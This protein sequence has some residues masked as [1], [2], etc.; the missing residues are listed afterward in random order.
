[1]VTTK[2]SNTLFCKPLSGKEEIIFESSDVGLGIFSLRSLDLSKDLDMIHD[3]VNRKYTQAFWQLKGTKK[4]VNS[5][6]QSILTNPNTHSLIGLIN[7]EPICQIDIYKVLADELQQHIEADDND[8]GFH[9]LM[10][11]IQIKK[12]GTSLFAMQSF[13]QYYFSFDQAHRLW[14]EPDI[15]NEKANHLVRKAGFQFVKTV[16][17]SYKIAN[18]YQL[19]RAEL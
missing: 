1:M 2:E 17:L 6:Y 7:G 11:P 5:I 16:A 10:A 8:S 12:A 14:G 19:T 9:F 18:L 4:A 13:I 15:E 3:W